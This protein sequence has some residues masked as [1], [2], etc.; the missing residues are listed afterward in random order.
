MSG[1]P[2]A[3][4]FSSISARECARA[5]ISGW[6]SRLGFLPRLHLT[7]QF[8]SCI[9]DVLCY[10]LNISCS[11]TTSFH[12]QSNR[13]IECFHCSLKTSRCALL[14]CPDWCDHFTLVML[15][16]CSTLQD[17][18]GFCAA[19]ELLSVSLESS[20]TLTSFLLLSSWRGFNQPFKD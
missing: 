18:S 2:E 6:I 3:I 1:R 11:R 5:L 9:W 14:A 19:M 4:P 15:S 16:L 10:L 7:A 12:L 20:W 13:L 17:E 8:K